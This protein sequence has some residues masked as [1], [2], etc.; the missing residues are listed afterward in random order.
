MRDAYYA[1][2]G[3]WSFD[4][5]PKGLS[6]FRYSMK[7]AAF[8][9]IGN[10]FESV[11][12]GA[13][14]SFGERVYLTEDTENLTGQIGGGGYLL[15]VRIDSA[16]ET[17]ELAGRWKTYSPNPSDVLVNPKDNAV[18]VCHHCKFGHATKIF[19]GEKG[20]FHSRVLFDDAGLALFKLSPEGRIMGLTD[21]YITPG[22]SDEAN[23]EIS[24][25]HSLSCDPSGKIFI[26]CDKG[27]DRLCSFRIEQEKLIPLDVIRTAD[28]ISPRNSVFHPILPLIYMNGE[29]STNLQSFQYDPCTG[30]LTAFEE[31]SLFKSCNGA[32]RAFPSDLLISSD[33]RYL[34]C[35]IREVNLIAVMD[36]DGQG[37]MSCLQNIDCGGRNPRG[38]CFSP[39][40]RFLFCTNSGS[41]NIAAFSIQQD[42]TLESLGD[43]AFS[44]CP[45]S[46]KILR[47]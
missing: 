43:K 5:G 47:F 30:K 7:D 2:V 45:S 41:G 29:T 25:Q 27:T 17:T 44:Y 12:V 31:T 11:K 35:A 36:L 3:N 39:D 14:A 21:V 37:R 6:V 32:E 24:H 8:K 28:G 26:L 38:L 46:I 22:Y 19:K 18:L 15:E 4:P 33:G 1:L 16:S 42:G 10:Y 40:H 13:I 20:A 23:H 34:Y 9:W